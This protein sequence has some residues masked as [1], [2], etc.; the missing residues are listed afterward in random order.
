MEILLLMTFLFII[1][2]H[3][4]LGEIPFALESNKTFLIKAILNTPL[5][6]EILLL[7]TFFHFKRYSNL[8]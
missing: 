4:S 1:K 6:A 2:C 8:G 5:T 3:S 7:M